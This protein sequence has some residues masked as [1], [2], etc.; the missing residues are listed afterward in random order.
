ATPGQWVLAR[1]LQ[2]G[3]LD[4]HLDRIRPEYSRRR[5]ALLDA[6]APTRALG[7]EWVRPEGGIFVWG[8]LPAGMSMARLLAEAAR[9]RV[10]FLPGG[11]CSADGSAAGGI[12]LNFS[13]W[14]VAQLREGARRLSRALA[15]AARSSVT[16][17]AEAESGL[18]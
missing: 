4:R 7:V 2:D 13:A 6:L 5:D 16:V 8:R 14:P 18:R 17:M 1:F 12:R 11:V 9:E 10:A 15:S 3:G